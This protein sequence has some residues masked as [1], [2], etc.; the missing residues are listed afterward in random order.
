M[1]ASEAR[2]GTRKLCGNQHLPTLAEP[3]NAGNIE[4]TRGNRLA[5]GLLAAF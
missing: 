3:E 1:L 4:S 5:E 2:S